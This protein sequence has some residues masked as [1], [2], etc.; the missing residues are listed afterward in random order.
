MEECYFLKV[1]PYGCFLLFLNS[2]NITE[3]SKAPHIL[4]HH[5]FKS[6]KKQRVVL[7]GQCLQCI[8][9]NFEVSQGALLGPLLFL[10]LH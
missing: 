5:T 3:P 10:N 9:V 6:K 8:N 4:K 7:N 2:I 1:T